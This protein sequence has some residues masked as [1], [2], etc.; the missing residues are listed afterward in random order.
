MAR[1]ITPYLGDARRLRSCLLF[2]PLAALFSHRV[3]HT[4]PLGGYR[5]FREWWKDDLVTSLR[6][7]ILI[8]LP[9]C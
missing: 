9:Y 2:W 3:V 1:M 5:H 8:C 4:T 7:Y 6:G